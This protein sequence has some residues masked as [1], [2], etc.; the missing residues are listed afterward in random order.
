MRIPNLDRYRH[1]TRLGYFQDLPWEARQ[2]AYQWLNRFVK[3]R[4]GHSRWRS[5][6]AI[7][8]LLWTS[9]TAGTESADFILGPLD[10]C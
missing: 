2:R 9:K 10:A 5:R 7:C 8:D 1:K 4:E 3:R 6:L